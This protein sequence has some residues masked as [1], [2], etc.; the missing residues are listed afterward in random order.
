[1]LAARAAHPG[2][3][4]ADLYDPD[5]VPPALCRARQALDR[6]ADRLYRLGGFASERARVEYLFQRYEQLRA[7]LDAAMRGTTWPP[8]E[9]PVRHAHTA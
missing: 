8:A 6:V 2:A 1:M 9:T 7:P 4:L 3:T 5:L